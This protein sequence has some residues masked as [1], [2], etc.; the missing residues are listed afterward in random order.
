MIRIGL[1]ASARE[2]LGMDQLPGWLDPCLI[3]SESLK[4]R[5]GKAPCLIDTSKRYGSERYPILER[6]VKAA[7][8]AE[9]PTHRRSPP[10]SPRSEAEV[11]ERGMFRAGKPWKTYLSPVWMAILRSFEVV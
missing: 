1:E 7:I 8:A 3:P 9:R 4:R 11:Q 6:L 5:G 2:R 10:P